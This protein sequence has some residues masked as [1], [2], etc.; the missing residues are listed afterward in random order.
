LQD[1]EAGKISSSSAYE[2]LGLESDEEQ[3]EFATQ[4]SETGLSSRT[5]RKAIRALREDET[6]DVS[7]DSMFTRPEY[8]ILRLTTL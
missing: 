5:V 1:V 7:E 4:I 2:L 8:E 6:R 3:V